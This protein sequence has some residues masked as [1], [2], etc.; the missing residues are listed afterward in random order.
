MAIVGRPN[1]GKSSL[2]NALVG[3]KLSSVTA[4]A[5]TT[6]HR[7]MAIV[8]EPDFQL[9]LV[10]TPGILKVLVLCQAASSLLRWLAGVQN[11][12]HLF[13]ESDQ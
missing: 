5:Q 2:S 6:R 3:Q 11:P 4:K 13:A 8:S 10:D 7:L 12:N 1:A 9:V